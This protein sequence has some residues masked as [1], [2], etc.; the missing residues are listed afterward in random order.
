MRVR[1]CAAGP[2]ANADRAE[3]APSKSPR[4][5]LIVISIHSTETQPRAWS[6]ERLKI[7][8]TAPLCSGRHITLACSSHTVARIGGAIQNHQVTPCH[9]PRRTHED[10]FCNDPRAGPTLEPLRPAASHHSTDQ[11]DHDGI[12]QPDT[13]P[14]AEYCPGIRFDP[15]VEV[16]L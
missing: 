9:L 2:R 4:P 3:R 8:W 6:L 16:R 10:L 12:P 7:R 14:R 11:S 13:R 1:G 15:R 5:E